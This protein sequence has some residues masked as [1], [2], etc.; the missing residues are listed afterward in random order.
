VLRGGSGGDIYHFERGDGRDL[1]VE[2]GPGPGDVIEFGTGIEA[3]QIWF[4][5]SGGD[6]TLEII[7]TADSVT[8]SRW[9]ARGRSVETFRLDDGAVLANTDVER[10]VQAMAAFDVT[11][12]SGGS[13]PFYV[14]E[15]IEPVIAAA[16]QAA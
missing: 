3:D 1:V 14:A 12:G 8:L 9:Y 7:G 2:T 16:W 4:S 15:A 10:L 6:L 11:C 5:R 13:L